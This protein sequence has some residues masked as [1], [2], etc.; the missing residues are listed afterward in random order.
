MH[1][2]YVHG[3]GKALLMNSVRTVL[4]GMADS[5]NNSNVA[6]T[7]LPTHVGWEKKHSCLQL[8][9][10]LRETEKQVVHAFPLTDVF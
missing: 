10:F 9:V 3:A 7:S 2:M 8:R 5:A 4:Y 1:N 6:S